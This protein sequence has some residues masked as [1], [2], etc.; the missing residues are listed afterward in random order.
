MAKCKALAGSAVKGLNCAKL[1]KCRSEKSMNSDSELLILIVPWTP[2]SVLITMSNVALLLGRPTCRS[3][4]L[5]F[6]TD[7]SFFL[8]RQL[9]AELAERNSAICG[10]I[11]GS[12]C[13]LKM[14]VWKVG[15]PFPLRIR[16]P[17]TTFSHARF[18]NLRAHLTAYIFG[19][20][21]HDIRTIGKGFSKSIL[22]CI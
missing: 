3:A 9:P 8:F 13:D 14:H 12:K 18:R 4:D 10:H 5:C 1:C 20:K 16:G 15:Y 6:T 7:S 11:L 2:H 22:R 17:K 19:T 21:H